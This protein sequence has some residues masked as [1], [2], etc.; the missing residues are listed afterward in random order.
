MKLTT[1]YKLRKPDGTDVVN[2]DDLNSNMDTLDS[3]VAKRVEKEA[4]KGLSTNDYTTV[5]KNKLAGVATGANNYSHPASHPASIITE[6]VNKRFMTDAE[7]TKLSKLNSDGLVT[8]YGS[9]V[10]DGT[11]FREINLGMYPDKLIA[12]TWSDV[13][14]D[15]HTVEVTGKGGGSEVRIATV[16]KGGEVIEHHD[17]NTVSPISIS[18][19]GLTI[20]KEDVFNVVGKT[21]KY[22]A[23][24]SLK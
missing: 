21:Y 18:R 10:G 5:E 23:I 8:V 3:E 16:F 24:G 4:G 9:Y 15:R 12:T 13:S 19:N 11:S 6:A 2:I 14:V 17:K 1:N 7:R 20:Y 22:M